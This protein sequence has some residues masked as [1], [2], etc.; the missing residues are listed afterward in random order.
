MP[1]NTISWL[2]FGLLA[3]GFAVLLA[4]AFI[5]ILVAR[6]GNDEDWRD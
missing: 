2:L 6:L 3:I 1:I 4:V 5:A